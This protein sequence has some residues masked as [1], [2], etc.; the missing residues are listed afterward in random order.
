MMEPHNPENSRSG[1][2]TGAKQRR[3]QTVFW[4]AVALVSLAVAIV[5]TVISYR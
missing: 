5:A 4:L 1:P 2:G 3:D